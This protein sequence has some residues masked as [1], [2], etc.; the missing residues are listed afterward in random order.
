M[1]CYGENS[2]L[3]KKFLNKIYIKNK[4]KKILINSMSLFNCKIVEWYYYLIFYY[5]PK[6]SMKNRLKYELY[7]KYSS[8]IECLLYNPEENIFYS[9][10]Y[11]QINELPLSPKANLD[12]NIEYLFNP[13][14]YSYKS[15]ISKF[16]DDHNCYYNYLNEF[17]TDL[18]I[19]KE[20]NDEYETLNLNQ[21]INKI[22]EILEIKDKEIFYE[23]RLTLK[24]NYISYPSALNIFIYKKQNSNHYFAITNENDD[25]NFYDLEKKTKINKLLVDLNSVYFYCLSS[26]N[27]KTK[28]N[29]ILLRKRNRA[30]DN[31]INS[32]YKKLNKKIL[33]KK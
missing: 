6:D 17:I 10:E 14:N 15:T 19:L 33:N 2:S 27:P 24:K 4:L 8:S 12:Y 29:K 32:K 9:S 16:S 23:T 25:F 11:K 31:V 18:Q 26:Q 21:I 7:E 5:N 28:R 3:D 30:K 1:K 20:K 22:K 13:D